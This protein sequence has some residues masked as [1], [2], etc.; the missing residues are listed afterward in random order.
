ME[1]PR[2]EFIDG[3]TGDILEAMAPFTGVF[4]KDS[5]EHDHVYTCLHNWLREYFDEPV[6][7]SAAPELVEALRVVVNGM[8]WQDEDANGEQCDPLARVALLAI[9]RATGK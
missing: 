7:Y 3:F 6:D 4:N 8:G 9:A 2:L 5:D 1:N